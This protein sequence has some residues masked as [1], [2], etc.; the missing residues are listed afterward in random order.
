MLEVQKTWNMAQM[1]LKGLDSMM[2]VVHKGLDIL[3]K[4]TSLIHSLRYSVWY[5]VFS[6]SILV[7][8]PLVV[9]IS[10]MLD[11][12]QIF[13]EEMDQFAP[14]IQVNTFFFS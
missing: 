7:F 4:Q 2:Q 14:D 5:L 12:W 11:V 6:L 13:Q 8:M 9:M 10:K 3:I 1:M